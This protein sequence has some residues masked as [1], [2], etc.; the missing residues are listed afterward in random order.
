LSKPYCNASTCEASP[1]T[2]Y[3]DAEGNTSIPQTAYT[4][5][6]VAKSIGGGGISNATGCKAFINGVELKD[7]TSF[8]VQN[9]LSDGFL[10]IEISGCTLSFASFYYW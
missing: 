10:Y 9:A 2:T 1:C 4:C 3:T 7:S 6:R 8:G 5:F